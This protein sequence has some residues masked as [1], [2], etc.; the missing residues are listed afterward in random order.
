MN[1]ATA[2]A[3]SRAAFT[4]IELLVVVAVIA[5]LVGLLLPALGGARRAA[6]RAECA[7]NIRQLTLANDLYAQDHDDRYMPGAREIESTNLHRWHGVRS[8]P[9]APFAP[10]GAPITPYLDDAA[11]SGAVRLCPAFVRMLESLAERGRGFERGCGGYGYN[12]AYVGTERTRLPGSQDIW[13]VVTDHVGAPRPRFAAP[14]DT[15]AFSDS[16]IAEEEIVEYSFVEPEFWPH[17]P[18]AKPDPS[19]HFR[20]QQ[21]ANVAWLDGHVSSERRARTWSSGVYTLD[22]GS[23]SIGWFGANPDNSLFDMR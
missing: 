4:L 21:Q 17:L 10:R 19:I 5:I 1:H 14:A 2:R 16:A 12:N 3:P 15:I 6:H 18:G 11:L 23:V 13:R 8:N 9:G 7:S 20:H 22:P